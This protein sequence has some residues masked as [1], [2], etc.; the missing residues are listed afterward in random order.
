MVASFAK[1]LAHIQLSDP[2]LAEAMGVKE[3]LSWIEHM[4]WSS[5][6]LESDYLV[7]VV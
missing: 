6:T 7:V 5:V 4:K 3:V 1:A 2:V